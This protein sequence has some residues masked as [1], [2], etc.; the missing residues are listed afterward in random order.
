MTTEDHH[1]RRTLDALRVATDDLA[2]QERRVKDATRLRDVLIAQAVGQGVASTLIATV[3][4]VSAQRIAQIAPRGTRS[5]LKSK[6][7]P[8]EPTESDDAPLTV[9][10]QPATIP[11]TL[12]SDRWG[13]TRA[14]TRY[15]DRPTAFHPSAGWSTPGALLDALPL[16]VERVYLVGQVPEHGHAAT[17]A[18]RVRS[19]FLQPVDG[20]W[21]GG[22]RTSTA[23]HYLADVDVPVGRWTDS[24]GRTVELHQAAAWTG[25]TSAGVTE[26]RDAFALVGQL[27]SDAFDGAPLLATPAT[28]GR[29]LWRRT[30][31]AGKT[32][33]VLSD[34]MRELIRSTSGQGRIELRPNPGTVTGAAYRGEWASPAFTYADGVLMY[35]GLTWGM[36]GGEP[37]WRTARDVDFSRDSAAAE[38]LIRGRGRWRVRVTVPAGWAH[39]GLLP[40]KGT[41]GTWR[42]PSAPGETFSSWVDG[43][44][45][46][47]A[48]Q[49]GWHV[50]ILEGFTF[51]EGKPLDTW[52]KKLVTIWRACSP[53]APAG[54][55]GRRMIRSLLLFSIGAFVGAPHKVTRTWPID[56]AEHAPVPEGIAPWI[57][58]DVLVWDE[59]TAPGKWSEDLAHPEYSAT[60]WAR[61][62][63]RLLDAPAPNGGRAGALHLPASDVIGFATDALYLARK[64]EWADSTEPGQFR[65][66]GTISAPRPWPASFVDLYA[67]RDESETS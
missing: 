13:S 24:A 41:S 30:I 8:A 20:V 10:A 34:E 40:A 44:E 50:E 56:D 1:Q 7:I 51:P 52:T 31:P 12:V 59:P 21:R 29:D 19:W 45:L 6:A 47:M 3:A 66:K 65:V 18:E 60:I 58:G 33:P 15:S 61:A 43:A 48:M 2:A 11:A 53:D 5:T 16:N 14:Q 55:L 32:W 23:G 27:V 46:W 26:T 57:A 64:P 42:Y 9:P 25:D 36:P 63:M 35:A 62:R 38:R 28:T 22:W 39:V 49:Q 4:N 17:R 54:R 37:T 67:L